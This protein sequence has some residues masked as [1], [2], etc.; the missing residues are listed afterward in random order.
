[1][2]AD[3]ALAVADLDPLFGGGVEAEQFV[4]ERRFTLDG[5]LGRGSVSYRRR[6]G[7]RGGQTLRQGVEIEARAADHDGVAST[8]S[9]IG[10]GLL[11]S[12]RPAANRPGLDRVG[13]SNQVVRNL[14][15][16]AQGR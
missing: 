4:T 10:Q 11:S 15:P 1:M 12:L 14:R 16:L 6:H 9:N 5:K 7:G 3:Q 13:D 8:L 2:G